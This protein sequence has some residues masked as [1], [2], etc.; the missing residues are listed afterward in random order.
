MPSTGG[1]AACD[2]KGVP[3]EPDLD[4]TAWLYV[5]GICGRIID[6]DT[7]EVVGKNSEIE[8]EE[9]NFRR[10]IRTNQD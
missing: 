7:M 8:R 6:P 10:T 2:E 1:F 4:W 5:C 9:E 3:V